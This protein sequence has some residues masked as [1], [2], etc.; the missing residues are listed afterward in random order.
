[1]R[2]ALN[3]LNEIPVPVSA[4]YKAQVLHCYILAALVNEKTARYLPQPTIQVIPEGD[5]VDPDTR[6]KATRLEQAINVGNFEIERRGDGDCWSRVIQDAVLLDEGVEILLGAP[7]PFWSEMV[8]YE[9]SAGK[10][11]K[12]AADGVAEKD[13]PALEY[14]F[15]GEPEMRAEYK[16][17]K[18]VPITRRYVPLEDFY[19]QYDGPNLIESFWVEE[20]SVLSV[21]NNPLFQT[22]EGKKALSTLPQRSPSGG[23]DQIVNIV[24]YVNNNWHCYYLAGPANGNPNRWPRVRTDLGQFVNGSL[25]YLYGYQHGIG[26]SLFNCVG[27]RYGGWKTNNNRIEGVGK[28]LLEL[29]QALDEI[30]SQMF[31]NIRATHW[32]NLLFTLDPEQRGYGPGK[33]HPDAPKVKEGEGLVLFKGEEVGNIFRPEDDPLAMWTWDKIQEAIS[34]MGGSSVLFGEKSPGVDTGYHQALQ[35][36]AAQSLDEKIEQHASF[37]AVQD[38]TIWL[39]IAKKGNVGENIYMH[40]TETDPQDKTRKVGQYIELDLADL[41]PLPR[42][43]AQVTKPSPMDYVA[44]LA[45]FE[46]ATDDRQGKGPALSDDTARVE[47]LGVLQPDVEKFKILVESQEREMLK[48]G[49]ISNRI[50]EL[51]NVKLATQGTPT[52]GPEQLGKADPALLAAIASGNAPGGPAAAQGGTDPKLLG[53]AAQVMPPPPAPPGGGQAPG[54]AI[55]NPEMFN[56]VGE[57]AAN[58]ATTGASI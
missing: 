48:T 21:M 42:L 14:E 35:K 37:G 16:K 45:A 51:A 13:L 8:T 17:Q 5:G 28:G 2:A 12:A 3:G 7:N 49:A 54:P 38:T 40:Y 50:M 32:P 46:K 20:R 4:Q 10:R 23:M 27:G 9:E 11:K 47:I 22:E 1:M 53:A 19:P 15:L 30:L 33:T 41:T 44:A 39:L 34:K 24:Q 31:T 26:R 52:P 56:R 36:T 18:G 57:A 25:N 6:A 55:G 58:A 29:S 43:D